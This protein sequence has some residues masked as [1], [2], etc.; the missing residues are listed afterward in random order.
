M[1]NYKRVMFLGLHYTCLP[2]CYR[3][4][5]AI[6]GEDGNVFI[7]DTKLRTNK[8]SYLR[9]QQQKKDRL[10]EADKKSRKND[11]KSAPPS[12]SLSHAS[13][14]GCSSVS[15]SS[16][17]EHYVFESKVGRVKNFKFEYPISSA[18][19]FRESELKDRYPDSLP[20]IKGDLLIA[21]LTTCD[22]LTVFVKLWRH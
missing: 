19:V 7:C 16:R 20:P 8:D 18:F 13:S 21:L 6:S 22:S 12:G 4:M 14:D 17:D 3:R 9:M 5:S 2:S 15:D 1:D 11:A 10:A